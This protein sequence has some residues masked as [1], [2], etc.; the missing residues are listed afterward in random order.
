[1]AQS[2][3]FYAVLGVSPTATADEVKKQYRRLEKQCHPDATP[4]VPKAADRLK[5]ISEA[6]NVLG[7]PE[8]RKQYDDMR[9]LGA[10]GGFG[11]PRPRGASGA[12][13]AGA[14]APGA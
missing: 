4:N 14:G 2:K 5:E 11:A 8:K 9:R 1:M 6:N 10:F 12:G 7:D 3:D 13:T